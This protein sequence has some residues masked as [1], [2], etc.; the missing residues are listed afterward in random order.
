VIRVHGGDLSYSDA[1]RRAVM[2]GG[3]LGEVIA[4]TGT[5]TSSSDTVE[6]D[7]MPA[8]NQFGGGAAQVDRMTATGHVVLTLEARRGTGEQLVYSSASGDYVLTGTAQTPPKMTD[9][10]HGTVTGEALIFH[11]RDDRV[12]IEGGGRETQT[13]TIAPDAHEK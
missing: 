10:E 2:R 13:E 6:L 3:S 12:S 5:A 1:D 4:E 8:G 7:L 11:R 9:P